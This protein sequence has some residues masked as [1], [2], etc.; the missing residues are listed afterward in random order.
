MSLIHPIRGIHVSIQVQTSDIII[1]PYDAIPKEKEGVYLSRSPYNFSHLLLPNS[2]DPQY[3]LARERLQQWKATGIF[4]EEA[5]PCYYLY[6]Q[7]FRVNN[8]SHTRD[9]LMC[10]VQL[11]EFGDGIVRPH[12]NTYQKF[13]SDR[14][15]ILRSTGHQMS[16]IFGMIKDPRGSLSR[17][18]E[19]WS[20][21]KPFRQAAD[22]DE[23][24]HT[25]WKVAGS[26]YQKTIDRIFDNNPIYIVDGHHRYGSA[27]EYAKEVGALGSP[28]HPGGQMLFCIANVYDRAL[29]V[30]PTH[31]LVRG[32]PGFSVP[33]EYRQRKI[34]MEE[35]KEFTATPQKG[36]DFVLYENGKLT[37]CTPPALSVSEWGKS[38]SK[39][40]VAWSDW[41]FL[42]GL[43]VTEENRSERVLYERDFEQA[44][45]RRDEFVAV[46]FHAPITPERVCE[47]A[48]EARF[49][50]QKTTYFYP[51]LAAGLVIRS[52]IV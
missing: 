29:V 11:H 7:E 28:H 31:R 25:L 18:F 39:L 46:L 35:L 21:Q 8:H 17:L 6:R 24:S 51:K 50:P 15:T 49:M 37:L 38:V 41:H 12:E 45:Q 30:F 42:P 5:H 26:D 4:V 27:L 40:A 22:D 19:S 3:R 16:H 20:F 33:Q 10:A 52:V 36:A 32:K 48:D 13:K 44:W 2:Q 43:G 34:V 47:V 9:T 23:T 1:P 14:L